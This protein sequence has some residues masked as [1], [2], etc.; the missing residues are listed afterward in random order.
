MTEDNM[1]SNDDAAG[2]GSSGKSGTPQT[3]H[4]RRKVVREGLKLVFV[5]PMLTTFFARDALAA[6]SNHSCY[7]AGHACGGAT[8]EE[9]C[10]G[11][12]CDVG[13]T[14]ECG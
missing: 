10:P 3:L 9:C 11:L 7:P 2:I 14:D 13:G 5:A 12:T 8:L 4:S 6:G 1:T